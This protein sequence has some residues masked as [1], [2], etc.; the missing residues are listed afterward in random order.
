M[1]E[2]ELKKMYKTV[3]EAPSGN[4]FRV[5]HMPDFFD[6]SNIDDCQPHVHSFFE[7][8][9][10]KEGNGF[11]MVDF[12]NYEV[13]PNT[14]FFLSPGQVHHFDVKEGYKG[15]AIKMCTDFMKD[16]SDIDSLLIKYNTFYNVESTPNYYIDEGTSKTLSAIVDEMDKESWRNREFGNID[17]L[18]SWLRIF[19]VNILRYGSQSSKEQTEILKPSYSLFLKFRKLVEQN[20][21]TLHTVQQY[22]DKLNVAVRTLNKCVN[23]CLNES[24]LTYINNRIMLEAKRLVRYTDL[25]FKEI[26]IDLGYEEPSY[27]V[28]SFKRNV[29]YLPSEFR[30]M[31]EITHCRIK[32]K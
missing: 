25:M 28:K 23:D 2:E 32:D 22:A 31:D 4:G 5:E 9:W 15:V 6:T 20:F 17:V 8:L 30:Q 21:R 26:A 12:V 7:I 29:G 10:F 11:H 14:I 24:P 27:F 3:C 13:K 19:L 1:T 16:G 18:K